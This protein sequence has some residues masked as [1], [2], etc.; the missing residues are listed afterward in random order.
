MLSLLALCYGG[1]DVCFIMVHV[2]FCMLFVVHGV[3]SPLK[4]KYLV[5]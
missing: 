3:V 4:M 5:N 1:V 2:Y